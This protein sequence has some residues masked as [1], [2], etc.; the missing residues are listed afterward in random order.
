MSRGQ[1][2]DGLHTETDAVVVLDRSALGEA[3]AG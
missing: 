2:D 3:A 1:K